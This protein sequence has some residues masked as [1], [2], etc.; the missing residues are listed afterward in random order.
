[1]YNAFLIWRGGA[2]KHIEHSAPELENGHGSAQPDGV[3]L[4]V[5]AIFLKAT[6]L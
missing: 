6:F 5:K 4:L 2:P 3:F 1:V